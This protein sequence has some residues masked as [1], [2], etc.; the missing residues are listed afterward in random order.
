MAIIHIVEKTES[1]IESAIINTDDIL[2]LICR[3]PVALSKEEEGNGFEQ[4]DPTME[5][6]T[7]HGEN[8]RFGEFQSLYKLADKNGLIVKT[9]AIKQFEE[10]YINSV[11]DWTPEPTKEKVEKKEK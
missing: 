6:N 7:K 5:I 2:Q 1:S 3:Y 8:F 4:N 11:A 10:A 9:T